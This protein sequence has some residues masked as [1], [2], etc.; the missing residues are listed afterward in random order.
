M[1]SNQE[2]DLSEPDLPELLCTAST[3]S[4]KY[5]MFPIEYLDIWKMFETHEKL[6]WFPNEIDMTVDLKDWK[7]L[8]SDEQF[9]IKHVLAFFAASDGIVMENLSTRFAS[10]VQ[11]SEARAFYTIQNHIELIHSIVYSRL[12]DTYISDMVEKNKLFNAI[13][14]FPAIKSKSDWAIKWIESSNSFATR[15][16]A[17]AIVEGVFFSGS[18]CCIYWLKERGVM[19]GLCLSND[20]IA[21]DES[22]HT[23]FGTMLYRN[24]I[25]NKLSQ[26]QI[27]TIIR[28][29]VAI[30]KQFILEALPCSLLGMNSKLMETYIEYVAN[31][32]VSQLGYDEIFPG[33]TQPFAFM[34]RIC[35]TNHTNF[36]EA[37]A[38]EYQRTFD[39][40]IPTDTNT[41]TNDT[42][43]TNIWNNSFDEDF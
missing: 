14:N 4:N 36:F 39:I 16:V 1:S 11:I 38:T 43:N 21:R 32:L 15:L 27:D 29:A 31:R 12:I 41:T 22:L 17:F 10:E 28:E 5:T 33:V 30:E 35:L 23:D 6:F 25:V 9:F 26:K 37:R 2:F 34:D 24:Y 7:K 40:S 18:F 8:S 3:L 13:A 19:P 42:N 20:F